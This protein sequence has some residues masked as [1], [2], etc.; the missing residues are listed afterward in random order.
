M[1]TNG[2]AIIFSG[3]SS[4]GNNDHITSIKGCIDIVLKE[5]LIADVR[6]I[7]RITNRIADIRIKTGN[8]PNNL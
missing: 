4:G 5:E 3:I 8:I 6:E 2:Y 1:A 7:K